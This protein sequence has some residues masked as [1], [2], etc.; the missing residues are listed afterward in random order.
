MQFAVQLGLDGH[1]EDANQIAEGIGHAHRIDS[2]VVESLCGE[3][4]SILEGVTGKSHFKTPPSMSGRI[5]YVQEL[6]DFVTIRF[7]H[8]AK[9][10]EDDM[11]A[12]ADK[13]DDR[14]VVCGSVAM[15]ESW[16]KLTGREIIILHARGKDW[17]AGVHVG[18]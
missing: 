18:E 1:I 3:R 17:V 13:T 11:R 12:I 5:R 7:L 8:L 2:F 15:I 6:P 10:T 9:A 16:L 4:K 14:T